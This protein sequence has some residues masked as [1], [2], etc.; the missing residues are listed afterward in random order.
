MAT[1]NAIIAL[2]MIIGFSFLAE[3]VSEPKPQAKAVTPAALPQS[4]KTPI[5]IHTG[6]QPG[7]QGA[8]KLRNRFNGVNIVH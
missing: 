4:L 8:A 5:L 2:L 6:L 3:G 7:V 1:E